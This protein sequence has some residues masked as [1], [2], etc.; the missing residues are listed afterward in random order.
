VA[1]KIIKIDDD[2][3][4]DQMIAEVRI[5]KICQHPNIVTFHGAWLS[6]NELFVSFSLPLTLS[7]AASLLLSVKAQSFT[8]SAL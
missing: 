1:L 8:A 3:N 6:G 7:P 4:F 2:D 5:M